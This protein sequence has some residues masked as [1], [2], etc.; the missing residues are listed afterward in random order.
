MTVTCLSKNT[1]ISGPDRM[2]DRNN[3]GIIFRKL[4]DPSLELF[5]QD[6]SNEGSQCMF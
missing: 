4:F 2:G 5:W 6:G 3:L 1:L